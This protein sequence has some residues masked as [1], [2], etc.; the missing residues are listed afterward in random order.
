M[1]R[2]R[3]VGSSAPGTAVVR[4][5]LVPGGGS[6]SDFNN[7]FCAC[8]SSVSAS[9]INTKRRL[10]SNGRKEVWLSTS[11]IDVDLDRRLLIRL[12][13]EH[14]D[15]DAARDAIAGAALPAGIDRQPRS[16]GGLATGCEAVDRLRRRARHGPLADARRTR[17]Q[18]RRRQRF[19]LDRPREQRGQAAMADDVAEEHIGRIASALRMIRARASG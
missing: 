10:P 11:R 8:G 4:M 9:R 15:V 12:D 16:F 2:E 18:Q 19:A 5:K 13:G 17:E 3:T 7:E 14:V 1:Q 6:S